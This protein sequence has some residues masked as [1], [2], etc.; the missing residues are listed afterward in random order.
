MFMFQWSTKDVPLLDLV[1]QDS[2]AAAINI[3]YLG[4]APYQH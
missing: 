2:L 4:A 1:F 3:S